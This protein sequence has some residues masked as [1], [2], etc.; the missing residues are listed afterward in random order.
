MSISAINLMS[1]MMCD[2]SKASKL[3]SWRLFFLVQVWPSVC[4]CVCVIYSRPFPDGNPRCFLVAQ[5]DLEDFTSQSCI[6]S[7]NMFDKKKHTHKER[8]RERYGHV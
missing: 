8:E 2:M 1:H 5:L 7:F 4:V 3:G 6:F